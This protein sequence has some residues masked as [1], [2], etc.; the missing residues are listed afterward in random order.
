[1]LLATSHLDEIVG[2]RISSSDEIYE[3]LDEFDT[4]YVI[5]EDVS[6]R[7]PTEGLDR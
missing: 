4:C 3:R 7:E 2:E 1:M 5:L 6:P